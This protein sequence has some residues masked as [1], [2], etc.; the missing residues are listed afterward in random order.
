MSLP[1]AITLLLTASDFRLD[2][3]LFVMKMPSC[4]IGSLAR[5]I[6]QKYGNDKTIIAEVGVR[7]GEKMHEVLLNEHETPHAYCFDENYFVVSPTKLDFKR[8]NFTEY[9]SDGQVLMNDKEILTMLE[10][11][12]F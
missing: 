3:D 12:G 4:E 2:G 1:E 5:V 10:R 6:A 9:S 11:G 8:V 7:A